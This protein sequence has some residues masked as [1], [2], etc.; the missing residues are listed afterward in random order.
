MAELDLEGM[1][2]SAKTRV[3]GGYE[4][5]GK[6]VENLLD[7]FGLE[8]TA[9]NRAT[10]QALLNDALAEHARDQATWP[11]ET[12]CDRLD[13]AFSRLEAAGILARQDY[14][15]CNTCG[16]GAIHRE[17]TDAMTQGEQPRGYVFFHSQATDRVA[18][19]DNLYLN[20]GPA[21][22]SDDDGPIESVGREIEAIL[23]EEGL[24]VRW[25]GSAG[26]K[27][28]VEMTWR[29]RRPTPRAFTLS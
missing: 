18:Q 4:A 22:P 16:C 12:D 5:L 15:C 27:I 11:D 9:E 23:R 6:I 21:E 17:I 25:N 28:E 3:D 24:V 20:Y 8:D 7:E 29:R 10:A 1:R 19:G 13:R 14:T 26:A 2:E